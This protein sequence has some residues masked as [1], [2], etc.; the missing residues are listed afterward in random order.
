[1][2][3]PSKKGLPFI[4]LFAGL[5]L[6]LFSC[7]I[8]ENEVDYRQEMRDFVIQISDYT[9]SINKNFF[10]IPQNGQELLTED[11]KETGTP[12]YSYIFFLDG[13]GREDLFYGYHSDNVATPADERD[14][15]IAFL[16]IAKDQGLKVLVTDYCW[17]I[18]NVDES[19]RKNE[20]KGYISFAADHRELDS[21]PPYPALPYNHNANH[22]KILDAGFDGV[23]LDVID[24]FEYFE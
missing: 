20:D 10:I 16:N 14:T 19:Y 15:M 5:I 7:G 12:S 11:G 13:V 23:Y 18:A 6:I 9:K 8:N 2:K 4:L 17:T 21:I 24:A 22:I 3:K 1:M